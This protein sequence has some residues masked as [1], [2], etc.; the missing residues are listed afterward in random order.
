MPTPRDRSTRFKSL[1]SQNASRGGSAGTDVIFVI[2]TRVFDM[3]LC[4]LR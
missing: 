4:L 3:S 1:L 2:S